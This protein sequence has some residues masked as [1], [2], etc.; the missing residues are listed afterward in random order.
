MV[1]PRGEVHHVLGLGLVQVLVLLLLLDL[2]QLLLH[3]VV[4]CVQHRG[5]QHSETFLLQYFID[6]A[7]LKIFA[8]I[9]NSWENGKKYLNERK[10]FDIY[11]APDVQ[12]QF[13][14]LFEDGVA[15]SA[16]EIVHQPRELLGKLLHIVYVTVVADIKV[17]MY[18]HLHEVSAAVLLQLVEAVHLLLA[19]LAVQL[20]VTLPLRARDPSRT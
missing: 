17:A 5:G 13:M 10:I 2:D 14:F 9:K 4:S 15:Q 1:W 6:L 20:V 8:V 3:G 16:L 19:H 7:V 12:Q 11:L 18:P